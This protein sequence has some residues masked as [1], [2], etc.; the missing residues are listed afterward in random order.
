[1]LGDR[2]KSIRKGKSLTQQAFAKALSTSP[3]YISEIEKGKKTPGGD[4]LTSLKREFQVD[5]NWFLTGE[6]TE[7]TAPDPPDQVTQKINQMLADMPED[8]RRDVLK[9]AEEKKLLAE[10]LADTRGKKQGGAA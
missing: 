6:A 4:F 10:L 8:K 2:L 1:M 3:G 5:I 7:R 9:Y